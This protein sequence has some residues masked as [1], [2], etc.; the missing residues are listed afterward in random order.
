M[1]LRSEADGGGVRKGEWIAGAYWEERGERMKMER[2][3]KPEGRESPHPPHG[4]ARCHLR[5][6][7]L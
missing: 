7:T 6:M 3:G 1:A 5:A 2:E 4:E